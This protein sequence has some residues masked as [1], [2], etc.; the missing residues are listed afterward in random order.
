MRVLISA[1]SQH[2]GTTELAAAVGEGLRGR[3]HE[4]AVLPPEQVGSVAGYDA[5]VL[6]SAL[7]AGHWLEPALEL[8]E[9]EAATLRTRPVWLFSSGPV[10]DPKRKLVQKMTADP[11]E[12]PHLRELLG[13]CAHHIFA[14][15]LCR[16]ELPRTQ[17]LA[18]FL[19]PFLEGDF[20]DWNDVGAW[21]AE[22]DSSLSAARPPAPHRAAAG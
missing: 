7:Y 17:R 10:G 13:P 14:G 18:L 4:V 15:R 20:R 19:F 21:V 2:G 6:G 12:L 1:A 16:E 5:F 8:A 11:V 3:G 22:I 9:R